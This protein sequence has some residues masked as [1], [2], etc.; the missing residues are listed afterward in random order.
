[1]SSLVREG[2]IWMLHLILEAR[3]AALLNHLSG[4]PHGSDISERFDCFRISE[5]SD[6]SVTS[7]VFSGERAVVRRAWETR[8]AHA[9]GLYRGQMSDARFK[10]CMDY[11]S[12]D[13]YGVLSSP[14][15][16]VSVQTFIGHQPHATRSRHPTKT[17]HDV[18]EQNCQFPQDDVST[19]GLRW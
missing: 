18:R 16:D 17:A 3:L 8:K 15:G 11:P 6:C 14:S 19:E 10:H 2:A 5:A 7:W 9:G 13:T 12:Y 1:M 4:G